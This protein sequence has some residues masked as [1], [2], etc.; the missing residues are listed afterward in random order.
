M[1]SQLCPLWDILLECIWYNFMGI[2]INIC[3]IDL[4]LV[5]YFGI[6]YHL[7]IDAFLYYVCRWRSLV[8]AC[9]DVQNRYWSYGGGVCLFFLQLCVI[10][11]WVCMCFGMVSDM[12]QEWNSHF[13]VVLWDGETGLHKFHQA[14][15]SWN[16]IGKI[17]M[18]VFI[19]FPHYSK[20]WNFPNAL[21]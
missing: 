16:M 4:F 21:L 5:S 17:S 6:S 3:K 13:G 10:F 18:L 20:L 1:A 2:L 9:I 12:R 7:I 11:C 8:L 19:D 14:P 15:K